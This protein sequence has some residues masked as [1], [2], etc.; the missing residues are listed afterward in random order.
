M[1][2]LARNIENNF[3]NTNSGIVNQP[4]D[5][6]VPY[7]SRQTTTPRHFGFFPFFAKKPWQV[8]QA[9]IKHYTLPG[10]LVCDPFA[11]SGVTAVEALVLGRRAIAGD[12]NPI[13]RFIARTTAVAPVNID[14]LNAAFNR[15]RDIAKKPIEELSSISDSEVMSLLSGLK[16]PTNEIPLTVRRKEADTVDQLHTPRQLAGLTLLRDA[17]NQEPE[18]LLRDML[19]VAL[20]NTV[21]YANRTYSLP[22][23]KE[24]ENRRAPYTGNAGFLRRFSYSFASEALF[25]E[26]A[27]WMTFE[28]VY[29]NVVKTK[30]ETNQ[31]M[32]GW[33]HNNFAVT[34]SPASKIHEITGEEK[35]DYFFTDPPG[36]ARMKV[37]HAHIKCRDKKRKR[38]FRKGNG[39]DGEKQ[40]LSEGQRRDWSKSR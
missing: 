19:L 7:K 12:I 28:R 18:P 32:D 8:V 11:G 13:A 37:V 26:H 4:I 5:Y 20:A 23:A 24:G 33:Y 2:N 10:D 9:Y 1:T 34:N 31:L 25:Y 36:L 16:Y 21:R 30:T 14:D 29:G 17:I 39:E 6:S 22:T 35:V 3:D 38:G 27:V 40:E 15:V